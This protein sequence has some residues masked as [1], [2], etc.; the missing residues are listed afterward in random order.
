MAE[1]VVIIGVDGQEHV[2]PP[3]FDPKRAAQ[4]VRTQG[5]QP[6]QGGALFDALSNVP[7]DE[8]GKPLREPSGLEG[9][10][11][12]AAYPGASRGFVNQVRDLLPSFISS[13]PADG[14]SLAPTARRAGE[15]AEE[16]YG[17]AKS[18]T[19]G[20][21][22]RIRALA[23]GGGEL[24]PGQIPG[25]KPQLRK[26]GLERE[27]GGALDSL[28]GKTRGGPLEG[29]APVGRSKQAIESLIR[30]HGAEYG[31]SATATD[32]MG[33]ILAA[34]RSGKTPKNV[35]F[36]RP[37]TSTTPPGVMITPSPSGAKVP[38]IAPDLEGALTGSMK[39]ELQSKAATGTLGDTSK[40]SRSV[41]GLGPEV[42]PTRIKVDQLT[43]EM[44]QDLR[45]YYGSEELARLTGLSREDV[46]ARAPGP[47][48][49][50][51]NV[52]YRLNQR[53]PDADPLK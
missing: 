13:A 26:P 34:L 6:P 31:G 2:F 18:V 16:L 28:M 27:I 49:L 8:G 33:E 39:A 4:I 1:E 20:I 24:V 51:L 23:K 19:G 7:T 44:W 40:L 38:P 47:S 30:Q 3:G 11:T 22:N 37:K 45:R 25:I 42:N 35:S 50:P 21:I 14:R 17:P 43:P 15:R 53:L 32:P 41:L 52:E 29:P 9:M 36:G 46:L 12:G 5:R 48:R 10:L